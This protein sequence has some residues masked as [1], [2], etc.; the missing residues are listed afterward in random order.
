MLR[1]L[2]G[3]EMCIRDR[4]QRRV[5]G[6]PAAVRDQKHGTKMSGP[7]PISSGI[8]I[9]AYICISSSMLIV[10]K[11][12]VA[13]LP[14]P[15]FVTNLQMFVSAA[16]IYIM[17]LKGDIEFPDPDLAKIKSWI[18]VTT[19]WLLPILANMRALQLLNVETVLVFRTMTVLGVAL[20]D[21]IFLNNRI[22]MVPLIGLFT[23]TVGGFTYGIYDVSYN[24]EGYF[25][26]TLYWGT[27]VLNSLYIKMVFILSLIHISEPTRLLSISYAVFCLKKKKKKTNIAEN[28]LESDKDTSIC[29]IQYNLDSI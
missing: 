11:A 16:A 21:F 14:Y 26:A 12:A 25:W 20:G 10:N 28:I 4:Y 27:M 7:Q 22:Q 6:K 3:S 13:A 5:R 24:R 17:K 18:G 15:Y 23:I 19:A 2:V 8:A 1:S 9:V 29:V